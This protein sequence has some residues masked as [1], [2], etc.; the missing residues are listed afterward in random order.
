MKAFYACHDLIVPQLNEGLKFIG[1]QAIYGCT[2]LRSV[3]IPST[4]TELCYGAFKDCSNLVKV[5]LYEGLQTIGEHAFEYCSALRSVTIPST[6][7]KLGGLAFYGCS[8]A[9]GMFPHYPLISRRNWIPFANRLC[10]VLVVLACSLIY[11]K[12]LTQAL[13][14]WQM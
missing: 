3:N 13:P 1:Q 12:P 9:I 10:Y 5:Q 7:S 8:T 11:V 2:S 14:D 6:V 4:V